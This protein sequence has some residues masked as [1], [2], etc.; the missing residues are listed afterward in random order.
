MKRTNTGAFWLFFVLAL[1]ALWLAS[2]LFARDAGQGRRVKAGKAG[3][4]Q[5]RSAGQ[6]TA[7]TCESILK[8]EGLDPA[9]TLRSSAE[10]R[11]TLRRL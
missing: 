11:E 3:A 8:T 6:P 10:I 4:Q 2:S 5:E 9:I 7:A 1:L